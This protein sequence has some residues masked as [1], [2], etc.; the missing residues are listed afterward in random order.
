MTTNNVRYI[1]RMALGHSPLTLPVFPLVSAEIRDK[2]KAVSKGTEMCI[3]GYPR[4]AN[5]FFGWYFRT[6]NPG[7]KVAHHLH[8]PANVLAAVQRGIPTIIVLRPPESA[9]LSL[10]VGLGGK[11]SVSNLIREYIHFHR[12]VQMVINQCTI[13]DF[14]ATTTTPE[15]AIAALN[16]LSGT[17]FATHLPAPM[18]PEDFYSHA[19]EVEERLTG[20]ED[21]INLLTAPDKRK[22]ELKAQFRTAVQSHPHLYEANALYEAFRQHP[23]CVR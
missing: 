21:N 2:G 18:K 13:T 16:K 1:L 22:D 7:R 10:M 19:R 9:V 3:E 4:S 14:S 8:V 11:V 5:S 23:N 15:R 20:S 17:T 6:A 12:R